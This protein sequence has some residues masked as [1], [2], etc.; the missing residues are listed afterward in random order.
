MLADI[1]KIYNSIVTES[2]ELKKRRE[3]LYEGPTAYFRRDLIGFKNLDLFR[4]SDLFTG[5]IIVQTAVFYLVGMPA[6]FHIAYSARS[7]R[8]R[9][10][11]RRPRLTS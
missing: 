2:Q 1:D 4:A 5:I 9:V 10:A 3:M 8:A 6:W 7:L 11:L